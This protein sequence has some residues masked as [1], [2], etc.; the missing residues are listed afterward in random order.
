MHGT[1][2]I[3][4]FGFPRSIKI[5]RPSIEGNSCE[6]KSRRTNIKVIPKQETRTL[7]QGIFSHPRPF[8]VTRFPTLKIFLSIALEGLG[9]RLCLVGSIL[10]LC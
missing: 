4:S 7:R 2:K 10:S 6:E 1:S 3:P 8:I 5:F 9:I